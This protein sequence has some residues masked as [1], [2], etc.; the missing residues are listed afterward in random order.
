[1]DKNYLQSKLKS[2]G[3]AYLY[4]FFF[5]AHYLYFGKLFFQILFWITLGG[6]G[7][8]LLFDLFTLST[9]V[10]IYNGR[11]QA[12]RKAKKVEK[13]LIEYCVNGRHSKRRFPMTLIIRTLLSRIYLQCTFSLLQS[14]SGV[15]KVVDGYPKAM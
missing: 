5:G 10:K 1:M 4:F 11:I 12:Y 7:M 8:W 3:K 6:F 14:M 15:G 2:T 9:K 13:S